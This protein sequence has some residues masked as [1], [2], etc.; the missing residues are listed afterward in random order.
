MRKQ[1]RILKHLP[2]PAGPRRNIDALLRIEKRLAVDRDPA[3]VRAQ[4]TGD[5]VGDRRL[6]RAGLA[7][8][9]GHAGCPFKGGF[10]LEAADMT[11]QIDLKHRP[12]RSACAGGAP[13][14]PRQ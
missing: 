5:H 2:D 6:A 8:Q 13:R 12:L 14:F 11:F 9:G 7:E 10:N 1:A 4:K 3:A